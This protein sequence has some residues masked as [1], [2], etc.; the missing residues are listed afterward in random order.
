MRGAALAFFLLGL[1]ACA[2]TPSV[3]QSLAACSAQGDPFVRIAACTRVIGQRDLAREVRA[4]ALV[5]RG[6][7]RVSLAEEARGV[8][9]FGRALRLDPRSRDALLQ[10]GVA[11]FNRQAFAAAA[12][13]F[14][15]VLAVDPGNIEAQRWRREVGDGLASL[16]DSRLAALDALIVRNPQDAT[17]LN[18]RC[19]LR[20]THNA[21]LAAALADCN[22]AVRLAPDNDNALDSR[23]LVHYKRRDFAAALAD[24]DAA[25]RVDPGR[26]HYL[27]GRALALDGLGRTE[28]ATAAFR[29]AEAAEPGVTERYVGYGVGVN[30][31]RPAQAEED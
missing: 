27:F 28:E 26:G 4:Q 5:Q 11:H 3:E 29:A 16:F 25:L 20:V 17:A 18:D 14:D 2:R 13:D 1:V 31:S 23:G 12:R 8:A 24:Y 15:A 21:D 30:F 19:W 9:D 22:E 7:V 10:R 6:M